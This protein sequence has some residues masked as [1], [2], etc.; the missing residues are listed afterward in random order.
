VRA[1][2]LLLPLL[3]LLVAAC[4]AHITIRSPIRVRFGRPTATSTPAMVMVLPPTATPEPTPVPPTP[5]PS[6][7][8]PTLPPS[9][10]A[11]AA[12]T[13]IATPTTAE[14][15]A[16]AT[17]NAAT[18]TPGDISDA[19]TPSP[20]DGQPTVTP[21]PSTTPLATPLTTPVATPPPRLP[22]SAGAY[23]VRFHQLRFSVHGEFVQIVNRGPDQDLSGWR[24]ANSGA[25][26]A[27]AFP[28][29]YILCQGETVKVHSGSEDT[30]SEPG[31]LLWTTE[32]M[33]QNV[34]EEALLYD[35]E[36]GLVDRWPRQ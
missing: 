2:A 17:P 13:D 36:G 10:T 11:T 34:L 23:D 4:G 19:P 27:F 20:G 9:P 21:S 3:A 33:W 15:G 26:Q 1:R 14:T 25:D 30:P 8:S 29:G 32:R 5:T 18:V 31:H 28:D 16:P 12:P 35:A 22:S 24:L 6:P 7:S